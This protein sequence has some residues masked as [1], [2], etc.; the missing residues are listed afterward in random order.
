MTIESIIA[1]ND[2]PSSINVDESLMTIALNKFS[3]VDYFLVS[4]MFCPELIVI[5]NS[6]FIKEFY[7]GTNFDKLKQECDNNVTLMEKMVNTKLLGEFFLSSGYFNSLDGEK[8]IA[9][10]FGN[11]LKFFWLNWFKHNFPNKQFII[12]VGENLFPEEDLAITVY[13]KQIK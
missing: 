5:E 10:K 2:F 6:I 12:E 11:I 9:L 1:Q 3:I 7:G 8:A 4:A 13:Q